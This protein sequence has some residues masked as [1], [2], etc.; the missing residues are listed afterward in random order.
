MRV[1]NWISGRLRSACRVQDENHKCRFTQIN[2]TGGEI[3]IVR[4][5]S[6]ERDLFTA[7]VR[8]G[9]RVQ[10]FSAAKSL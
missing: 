10:K 5:D 7:E 8:T 6:G 2:G 3:Y 4:R 1:G 9:R